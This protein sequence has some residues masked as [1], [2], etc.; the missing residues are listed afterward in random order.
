MVSSKSVSSSTDR[1][2]RC[3]AFIGERSA[4]DVGRRCA[5]VD[6]PDWY[7]TFRQRARFGRR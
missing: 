7:G 3:S 6:W 4:M 1:W 2:R 5:D